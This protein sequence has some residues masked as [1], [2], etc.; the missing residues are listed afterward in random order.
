MDK[1]NKKKEI[2]QS[3]V[4]VI[5]DEPK[6]LGIESQS[7][8]EKM[9]SA[10]KKEIKL[11]SENMVA[12]GSSLLR[13]VSDKLG[14]SAE[15]IDVGATSLDPI[16]KE[17]LALADD[18]MDRIDSV[19]N[20]EEEKS[21]DRD[22]FLQEFK[23]KLERVETLE[24]ILVLI[25][26]TLNAQ[27]N[28][29]DLKI[30]FDNFKFTDDNGQEDYI[31]TEDF[32]DKIIKNLDDNFANN[33]E[34]K[35]IAVSDLKE[36]ISDSLPDL[37]PP[38]SEGQDSLEYL[39]IIEKFQ[40]KASVKDYYVVDFINFLNKYNKVSKNREDIL[41]KFIFKN[42]SGN[43]D[44]FP[45][46][47]YGERL[48]DDTR[49]LDK[50]DFVKANNLD[51]SLNLFEENSDPGIKRYLL[52]E[53]SIES[54]KLAAGNEYFKIKATSGDININLISID[55]LKEIHDFVG[56]IKEMDLE[57]ISYYHQYIEN[58]PADAKE[59]CRKIYKDKGLN[60][61]FGMFSY[62]GFVGFIEN[63]SDFLK[64]KKCYELGLIKNGLD[65]FRLS[66][67]KKFNE[68]DIDSLLK[69]GENLEISDELLIK[70]RTMSDGDMI[71]FKEI[72]NESANKNLSDYSKLEI[73]KYLDGLKEIAAEDMAF[74]KLWQNF[75]GWSSPDLFRSLQEVESDKQA[76]SE[77][78]QIYRDDPEADFIIFDN[79]FSLHDS[80]ENIKKFKKYPVPYL[81]NSSQI[82]LNYNKCEKLL[83]KI[84]I[85]LTPGDIDATFDNVLRARPGLISQESDF[86]FTPKQQEILNVLEENE[87]LAFF[88]DVRRD[89]ENFLKTPEKY[90]VSFP[91][92]AFTNY[93]NIKTF[94]A[95]RN[96]AL[97]Q[98]D[99]NL[100]FEN[101]LQS[102]PSLFFEKNDFPLNREQQK[103]ADTIE[104]NHWILSLLNASSSI[105]DLLV[106]PENHFMNNPIIVFSFY[107]NVDQ[108]LKE[109]NKSISSDDVNSIFDYV[110]N[111]RPQLFFKKTGFPFTLEQQKIIDIF[112][113]INESS[114][115][116]MKNMAL[117]L[118]LQLVRSGDLATIDERY[119]KIDNIFVKNNIPFV[120]K[121]AK[122]CE[123]L[124]PEIKVNG[125][126]SPELQSLH[127]NNARRLLIFKDLLRTSFNS[128]N[129]NLE[130]YLLIFK[131]GQEVLDKYEKGEVLSKDEEEKLKY[132]FKKIN[133]LSENTRKT[134]KFNK[135]DGDNLSLEDNLKALKHNFGIRGNQ[136]I[137][138]KFESTFL[139][140]IG[141]NNFTE[142]L[143]YYDN[144]RVQTDARN[145]ELAA[146][147]RINLSPDDLA[148]GVQFNFF[149]NN[150]D[151]GIMGAEFVGA[152]S[153]AAKEKS[154]AGDLTPWDTDLIRVGNT[155][156]SEIPENSKISG[157]GEVFLI[158][159]DRGQFNKNEVGKPL[160]DDQDKLEL[161]QTGVIGD[162]H[163][164]VRTG[165]GSTEI[166]TILVKNS[167][168]TNSKQLDSLKFSIAKKGFYIPI[169]NKTGQVI[170]TA[171]EFEEYRKI[172]AGVDRH[173]G[174]KIELSEEWKNTK[175]SEEIKK[176]AQTE[177]NLDKI[178]KIRDDIYRDM[179]NDL[180]NFGVE[181][182]KGRYDDSVAGAKIID[183]G[184]TGRGAALDEGYDF[185]FVVKIDDRD[186]D[187]IDKIGEIL[188]N[189]YPFKKYYERSG[190]RTFRFN[191]FEK[192][193]NKIE[194][195]ISFIKKSDS[196]ELDANEAIAL[197]YDAI[198]KNEGKDKLLDVLTNVRFAKKELKK[199]DCYKK[200]L[201]NGIQQG[202]LGGI[203][204][205]NWIV[206][207]GGDAVVAFR[208]FHE[209]AYEDGKLISFDNFKRKYPIFS[210][211][212][213]IR[214]GVRA[215]NFVYN[216][217]EVGYQK[218]AELSKKFVE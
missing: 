50:I 128:L 55:R 217:D 42:F 1:K 199:A 34:I 59:F 105:K 213:N 66:R 132:F 89:A 92:A 206:K 112:T 204:V 18:N 134:D 7:G 202:G 162:D 182:H 39:K 140:R 211:G 96:K 185:D 35:N 113:K 160:G 161:F 141:I 147:G 63:R 126:S 184:S 109:N 88:P 129:S 73:I 4:E 99:C 97:S 79:S 216:M 71:K 153:I 155:N 19:L 189:K 111:N 90:F 146:S 158:V 3:E 171:N 25:R 174:A 72:K 145:K 144:L 27:K 152:E 57:Q 51:E 181:L 38:S 127:S 30:L 62:G 122:I 207:N 17:I 78:A 47:Q 32:F 187:K 215:E 106:D 139:K 37:V 218:M 179:E 205:E 196:E 151:R 104:K 29:A 136:T 12:S 166:D 195:D 101:V 117:E 75:R 21:F 203:G 74:L 176:I 81:I 61:Q 200:G 156:I 175:F 86:P 157:Y 116:E 164:G 54:L 131:N 168:L 135:F 183:T 180:K 91:T 28:R 13:E 94:L 159:K 170:F 26:E 133:A 120:G 53:L 150:L 192:D 65:F 178:N 137:T 138:E 95:K 198:E 82:W 9:G 22:K 5:G 43:K 107:K 119:E 64:I 197:K 56:D 191:S 44:S 154:K 121:Q 186:Y 93:D 172:F 76:F 210:A 11:S 208:N 58:L 23:N 165:F 20:T 142:A 102:S 177:E 33:P 194:L 98:D 41:D 143:K 209:S 114:S 31:K 87:W 110:F 188:K 36:Q 52:D 149:D 45:E 2:I 84:G 169:C 69:V 193:G 103:I 173:H 14:A 130:Q 100:I 60:G 68:N 10:I 148:K 49:A 190:M 201:S 80:L 67:L 16:N 115:A 124:H 163:Y 8:L 167:V 77:L 118:S 85:K 15:E 108:F 48:L 6:V 83:D 214:G 212:E 46:I 125:K 40:N 123:A 70:I 24:K